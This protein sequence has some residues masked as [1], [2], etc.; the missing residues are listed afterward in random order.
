MN[1]RARIPAAGVVSAPPMDLQPSSLSRSAP[2]HDV[3]GEWESLFLQLP[4][5]LRPS[6]LVLALRPG[7]SPSN[8]P[9]ELRSSAFFTDLLHGRTSEQLTEF[10]PEPLQPIDK[11][12]DV[13]QRAAVALAVQTPDVALIRGVPGAGKSRVIA[14]IVRQA[15]CRDQ[16]VLVVAGDGNGLDVVMERLVDDAQILALRCVGRDEKVERLCPPAA[17]RTLAAYRRQLTEDCVRHAQM[18]VQRTEAAVARGRAD[19]TVLER[20]APLAQRAGE[21]AAARREWSERL[22]RLPAEVEH[23]GDCP[24][25]CDLRERRARHAAMLGPID[26]KLATA[27]AE[28]LEIRKQLADLEERVATE[29]RRLAERGWLSRLLGLGGARAQT[30]IRQL[31]EQHSGLSAIGR[32]AQERLLGLSTERD[33]EQRRWEDER[34]Q[35]LDAEISRRRGE[36][37]GELTRLDVDIAALDQRFRLEARALSPDCPPIG[38]CDADAI[39][40]ALAHVRVALER[41]SREAAI[42]KRWSSYLSSHAP[43][44]LSR[45]RSAFNVVFITA[46]ALESDEHAAEMAG[47]GPF[48]ILIVDDAHRLSQ[49]GLLSMARHAT[50]WVLV[51]EPLASDQESTTV[52]TKFGQSLDH[53]VW[54]H[55]NGRLCC[56]F[57]ALSASQR[58][59]IETESVA[60]SPEVELRIFAPENATPMLAEVL[61]PAATGIEQALTY[62]YLEMNELPVPHAA[63]QW[64]ESTDGLTYRYSDARPATTVQ[65]EPGL[66]VQLALRNGAWNTSAIHFDPGWNRQRAEDWLSAHVHAADWGRTIDLTISYRMSPELADFVSP[67]WFDGAL[68]S[69]GLAQPGRHGFEFIAVPPRRAE[70]CANG[71]PHRLSPVRGGAGFEIDLADARQRDRLAYDLRQSLPRQGLVNLAE[72]QATVRLLEDRALDWAGERLSSVV[73][74]TVAAPQAEL[75]RHLV[76]QSGNLSRF[77]LALR[78]EAANE[79]RQREA[80]VVVASLTRSHDRRAVSYGDDPMLMPMIVTR[81]RRRLILMGDAGALARRAQWDGPLD[82]F[83]DFAARQERKWVVAVLSRLQSTCE[84]AG[85]LVPGL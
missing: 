16:R 49:S 17:A 21:L 69:S 39:D 59:Q 27:K 53:R 54:Q 38:Q 6:F 25:T 4:Q 22:T 79:F 7:R 18:S 45:L 5:A 72:A 33:A 37:E 14:E 31:K 52:W 8:D 76:R 28:S 40:R 84:P 83:D 75:I 60:D 74:L 20:L 41:G 58:E 26:Q 65:L 9:A 23:T 48:D 29:Q 78:I 80:D 63:G 11:E 81:A 15:V 47:H 46:A 82:H 64:H 77:P 36:T 3:A 34:R 61:F 62:L 43:Q 56:R 1:T 68:R 12:L 55:E 44:L 32:R 57:R 70:P 30:R 19:L 51:G 85:R 73:V 71:T 67:L 35:F 50:H 10:C 24:F 13:P 66:Y 2:I 42:T